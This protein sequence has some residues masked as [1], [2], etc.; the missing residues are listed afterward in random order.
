MSIE[1]IRNWLGVCGLINMGM[2]MLWFAMM[3]FAH[4]WI[5]KM[6]TK[7]F[8]MSIERFDAIH[9]GG[10]GLFKLCIFVFNVVPWLALLIVA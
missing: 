9:Y 4:D 5:Y 1:M 2:L 3:I 6:H 10:M 8:K 7:W